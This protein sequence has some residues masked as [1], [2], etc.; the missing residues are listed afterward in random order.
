MHLGEWPYY[1]GLKIH[2]WWMKKHASTCAIPS[3][4]IGNLST[5]GTGKSSL[6]LQLT[7]YFLAEGYSPALLSRGYGRKNSQ[8]NHWVQPE[9]SPEKAGDEPLCFKQTFPLLHVLCA[10]N[11]QKGLQKILALK[12]TPDFVWM[13]DGFQHLYHIPSIAVVLL[14]WEELQGPLSLLP[15]G[16]LREPVAALKRAKAVLITKIPENE[17][18]DP[19]AYRAKLQLPNHVP[20]F[21]AKYQHALPLYF[22]AKKAVLITGIAQPKSLVQFLQNQGIELIHL[23]FPD[24]HTFQKK[25]VSSLK[26]YMNQGLPILTTAKD[27]PRLQAVGI[28]FAQTVSVFHHFSEDHLDQLIEIIRTHVGKY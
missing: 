21:T 5:G 20:L 15:V 16:P 11:R 3:V 9:D 23:N 10:A 7:P 24:H 17:N 19:N 27:Q 13:D 26:H 6:L 14:T 28:T 12:P 25:D 1:I 8:T 22:T 2:Q 4:I 18:P